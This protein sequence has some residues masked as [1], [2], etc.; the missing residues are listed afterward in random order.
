MAERS[1]AAA[2]STGARIVSRPEYLRFRII[3]CGGTGDS[4]EDGQRKVSGDAGSFFPLMMEFG[5]RSR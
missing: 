3:E 5:S 2:G 1:G 4:D